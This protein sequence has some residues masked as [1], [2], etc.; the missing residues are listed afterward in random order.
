MAE[1]LPANKADYAKANHL[2]KDGGIAALPTET[3]YGLAAR[4][5]NADA[6]AKIY[7]IKGRRQ[8]N[9]LTICVSNLAQAQMITEIS[10]LARTLMQAFWPGPLTIVLPL[11][12]DAPICKAASAGLGTLGLR[13]PNA[14][15][16]GNIDTPLVLP[17][18]NLSGQP[19]PK[20]AGEVAADLGE[21]IPLII[22]GGRCKLGIDST[23][24][25]IESGTVKLLRAGAIKAEDFAPYSLDW[26][27]S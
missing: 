1:I 17:S 9:P 24:V 20:T 8:S 25:S 19:S 18:A 12:T 4:A 3:V 23:V 16:V 15:W 7:S 5:D 11:K 27:S 14:D 10:P 2:L 26:T 21:H 13:M 22:D 6:I